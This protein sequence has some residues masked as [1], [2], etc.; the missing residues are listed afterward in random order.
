MITGDTKTL[1]AVNQEA[2]NLDL[3]RV[4][5]Q[6]STKGCHGFKGDKI[7]SEYYCDVCFRNRDRYCDNDVTSEN[8]STIREK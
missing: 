3:C 4:C 2:L 6:P 7:F 5:S 1:T 8:E